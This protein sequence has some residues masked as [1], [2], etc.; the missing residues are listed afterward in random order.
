MSGT[1][2]KGWLNSS[3]AQIGSE[4]SANGTYQ[5][6]TP[7]PSIGQLW[8]G[9]TGSGAT[10]T[11]QFKDMAGNNIGDS[12]V[13]TTTVAAG[14][15]YVTSGGVVSAFA[16]VGDVYAV[17]TNLTGTVTLEVHP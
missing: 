3:G 7:C 9:V 16:L 14:G 2:I 6:A 17:V 1:R 4:I 8:I 11:V 5:L 12:M 10:A 15:K 13:V